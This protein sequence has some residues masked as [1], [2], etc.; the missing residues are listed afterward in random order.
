MLFLVQGKLRTYSFMSVDT[1]SAG[2]PPHFEISINHLK[3]SEFCGE[4][5]V[6]WFQATPDIYPSART[7]GRISAAASTPASYRVSGAAAY[8]WDLRSPSEGGGAKRVISNPACRLLRQRLCRRRRCLRRL[9][10]CRRFL[11][12]GRCLVLNEHILQV[13]EH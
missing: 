1:S 3:D 9:R 8:K 2:S 5:L 11:H 13:I 10:F 6:A 7:S 12:L 4:E